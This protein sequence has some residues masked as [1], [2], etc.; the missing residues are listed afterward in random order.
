MSET[1]G[2]CLQYERIGKEWECRVV[3]KEKNRVVEVISVGHG[4]RKEKARRNQAI[5]NQKF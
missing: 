3:R 4:R 5:L 1:K 2:T